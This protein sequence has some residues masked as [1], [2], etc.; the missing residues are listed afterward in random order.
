VRRVIEAARGV[1]EALDNARYS[2]PE[3][4]KLRAAL[5][6]LDKMT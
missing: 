5:A 4:T 2:Y 1:M 3:R 6:E